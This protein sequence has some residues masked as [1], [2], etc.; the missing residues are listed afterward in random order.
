MIFEGFNI[1]VGGEFSEMF[2]F[3]IRNIGEQNYSMGGRCFENVIPSQI[4]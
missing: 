3:D 1:R 4:F 2:T